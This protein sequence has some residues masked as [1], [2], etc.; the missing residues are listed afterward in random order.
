MVPSYWGKKKS[1][2]RVRDVAKVD[3]NGALLGELSAAA[4]SYGIFY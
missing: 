1:V 2:N 4:E 3:R